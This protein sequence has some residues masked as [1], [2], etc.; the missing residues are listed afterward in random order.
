MN[1]RPTWMY[2]AG[3]DGAVERRLFGHPDEVPAG[4]GWADSPAAA[5]ARPEPEAP[6]PA[7]RRRAA[8]R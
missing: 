4:E 2:R 5:A 7:K 8:R 3:A 6:A 1:D